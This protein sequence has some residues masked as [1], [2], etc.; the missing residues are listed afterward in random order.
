MRAVTIPALPCLATQEVM[1]W[2]RWSSCG[3][4]STDSRTHLRCARAFLYLTEL[5]ARVGDQDSAIQ[6]LANV[7]R[8]ELSATDRESVASDLEHAREIVGPV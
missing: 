5:H 4:G 3:M 2:G 1:T 7:S 8:V 6:S